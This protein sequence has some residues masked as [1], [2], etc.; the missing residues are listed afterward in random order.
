M[1]ENASIIFNN[2]KKFLFAHVRLDDLAQIPQANYPLLCLRLLLFV[3]VFHINGVCAAVGAF[4]LNIP[5]ALM[6]YKTVTAA[7][8]AIFQ[9][10]IRMYLVYHYGK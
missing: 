7:N 9:N 8:R 2:F 1:S 10:K 6:N 4:N 3:G 5:T